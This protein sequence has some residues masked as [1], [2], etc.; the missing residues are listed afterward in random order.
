[1]FQISQD[2]AKTVGAGQMAMLAL[3]CLFA[4]IA[5]TAC[6]GEDPAPP[7]ATSVPA[8]TRGVATPVPSPEAPAPSATAEPMPAPTP[9]T[10]SAATAD[11]TPVP[12]LTPTP[13][14]SPATEPAQIPEPVATLEP[15]VTPSL[16][17]ATI[18]ALESTST[19]T[20]TTT[21]T[22][23]ATPTN[24]PEPTLTA[25]SMPTPT[26]EPT[27]TPVPTPTPHPNPNLRYYEEKQLVLQLINEAR[28]DSRV[29]AL[30]MGNNISAQIHAE[31]SL[32]GCYSSL[33]SADGLKSD[34][35]YTLA[36]DQQFNNLTVIGKDY[37]AGWTEKDTIAE[38]TIRSNVES[39]L[40]D[41]GISK[42]FTDGNYRKASIGLDEDQRFIRL[43]V[44]LEGDFIEYEQ[45]PVFNNGVLTFSGKVKN[46]IDLD[47]GKGLSAT[48]FYDPPPGNL[49]AGQLARV[50]SS[51]GGLRVAAIRRPASEGRRWTSHEYTRKHN[52]C[53]SPHDFPPDTRPPQSPGEATEFHDDAKEKCLEIGADE[54]GGQEITVPWITAS[55]WEIQGNDFAVEADLRE[56]VGRHGNGLYKITVW[57]E[58]NG[59]DIG[60]SE[61]VIFHGVQRPATYDPK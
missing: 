28:A 48:V 37:C 8:E 7:A 29:P 10:M 15:S 18:S 4:L 26:P 39:L 32:S 25:T 38:G 36:G 33:W 24:T 61:Y 35:R 21:P 31:D 47:G 59:E 58:L 42:T 34:A 54:D 41:F 44:L 1:M 20:A 57:G 51:D 11:E 45:L 22:P 9:T 14:P 56:V 19:P 43:A 13:T 27:S 52:P 23:T 50:Y 3:A 60:I 5:L 2:H 55:R 46:G 49:T 53:P 6:G 40:E 17:Q 30:A 12:I 16:I